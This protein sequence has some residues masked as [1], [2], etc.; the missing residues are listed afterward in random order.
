M[1]SNVSKKPIEYPHSNFFFPREIGRTNNKRKSPPP[2]FFTFSDCHQ[3]LS[4]AN[5]LNTRILI[6]TAF[7]VEPPKYSS[8]PTDYNNPLFSTETTPLLKENQECTVRKIIAFFCCCFTPTQ[9]Y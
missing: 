8:L 2:I 3:E 5:A 9:V 4:T 1:P 6:E 7:I